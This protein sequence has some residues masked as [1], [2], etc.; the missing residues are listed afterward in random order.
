MSKKDVIRKKEKK[1]QHLF[2]FWY[3]K[4]NHQLIRDK[5]KSIGREDLIEKLIGADDKPETPF[6]DQGIDD[7]LSWLRVLTRWL[8]LDRRF[9]A[10]L[11][12]AWSRRAEARAAHQREL[13]ATAIEASPTGPPPNLTMMVSRMRLSIS[14]RPCSSISSIAKALSATS[15]VTMPAART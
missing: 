11:K 7:F 3:K 10:G 6:T 4:E 8:K 9:Y 2:F 15:P 14:S 5:L 12:R 13:A 1:N